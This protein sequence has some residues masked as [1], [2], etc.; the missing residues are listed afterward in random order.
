MFRFSLQRVEKRASIFVAMGVG[1]EGKGSG[2]EEGGLANFSSFLF[3][4][5]FDLFIART[6]VNIPAK[7]Q[8]LGYGRNC[9]ARC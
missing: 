4:P 2:E 7:L 8:Y 5:F 6:L 3:F 1:G 9:H